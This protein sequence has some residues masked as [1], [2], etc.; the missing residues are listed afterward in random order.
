MNATLDHLAAA[1]ADLRNYLRWAL[2]G[3]SEPSLFYYTVHKGGSTLFSDY[4]LK[5][6]DG[7]RHVDYAQKVYRGRTPKVVFKP[8]GVAYGPIRVSTGQGSP[9]YQ[10][11]VSK[12]LSPDFVRERRCLFMVRDPRDVVV[13]SYYSFGYSHGRAPNDQIRQRQERRRERIQNQ[14]IDEYAREIIRA[15][16]ADLATVD[17]LAAACQHSLVVTFEQ[18]V[19]D[20]PTFAA[21]LAGFLRIRPKVLD[22]MHRRSRPRQGEDIMSHRRSGKPGGFREKLQPETIAHCN[23]VLGP[24]LQRFGY[25]E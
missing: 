3:R 23:E 11:F 14:T 4:T 5:H 21:A 18:M 8:R 12:T 25:T 17:R 16:A 7:L 19:D 2:G 1:A 24:M 6:L 15:R 10:Q 20:W 9:V 22:E 13:S